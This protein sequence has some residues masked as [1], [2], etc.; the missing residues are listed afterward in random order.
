MWAVNKLTQVQCYVLKLPTSA[1]AHA[2]AT[3][4]KL[5]EIKQ[6]TKTAKKASAK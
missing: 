6:A 1:A 5:D 4:L 3:Q 2:K